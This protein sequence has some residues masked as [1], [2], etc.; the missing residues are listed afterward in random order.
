MTAL[1]AWLYFVLLMY[2][3]WIQMR[4]V[5][6]YHTW[7]NCVFAFCNCTFAWGSLLLLIGTYMR[8][9]WNALTIAFYAGVVLSLASVL[10]IGARYR[11]LK[12]HHIPGQSCKRFRYYSACLLIAP[13]VVQSEVHSILC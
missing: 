4:H 7:V 10:V 12:F 11:A 9:H 5:P 3:Y 1:Q 2:N 6:Y 8:A 13:S